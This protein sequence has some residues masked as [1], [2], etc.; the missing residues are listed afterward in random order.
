MRYWK[1]EI[2]WFI[3]QKKSKAIFDFLYLKGNESLNKEMFDGL[4]FNLDELSKKDKD[5]LKKFVEF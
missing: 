5:E 4:R 1:K 3:K 2:F